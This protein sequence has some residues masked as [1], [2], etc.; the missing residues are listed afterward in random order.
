MKHVEYKHTKAEIFNA[1]WWIKQTNPE[2]CKST[3]EDLLS[4]SEFTVLN[5]VEHHFNQQG[6][7]CLWLLAE[8][9]LA[10]HTFPEEEKCY[11]E[12]SSCNKEKLDVF[13]RLI[14]PLI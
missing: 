7:T 12:L 9:H 5:V 2:F 6:Y 1:K 10:I 13:T 14:Q 4:K 3:C 8:S 11:I